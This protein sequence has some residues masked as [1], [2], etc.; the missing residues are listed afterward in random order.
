MGSLDVAVGT[1]STA[2]VGGREVADAHPTINN[3]RINKA[4]SCE[5]LIFSP[6]LVELT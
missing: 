6:P 4:R 3:N 5:F 1:V 2:G